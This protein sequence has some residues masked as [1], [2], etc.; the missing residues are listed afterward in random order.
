MYK[1]IG[2]ND[3]FWIKQS[4][5]IFISAKEICKLMGRSTEVFRL[6][7]KNYLNKKQRKKPAQ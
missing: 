6:Q 5:E 3:F 2:H 4:G 7:T 1:G